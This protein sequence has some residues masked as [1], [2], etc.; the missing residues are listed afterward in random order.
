MTFHCYF[1]FS[2]SLSSIS[3]KGKIY[4]IQTKTIA[5]MKLIESSIFNVMDKPLDAIDIIRK[6]SVLCDADEE[7]LYIC[8]I[9]DIIEKYANWQ[10]C[11]PRVIPFY[12]KSEHD[13]FLQKR[14]PFLH[15]CRCRLHCFNLCC[16]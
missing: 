13:F 4:Q 11:M 1:S 5:T 9:S 3:S 10:H 12:G 7:P 15:F 16:V 2:L 14:Y 6:K 8:N